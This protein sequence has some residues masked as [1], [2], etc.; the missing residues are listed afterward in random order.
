MA[1]RAYWKGYLKLSLVSCPIALFPATSEREKISFHQLNKKTGHRVKYRKVDAESGDEV[2]SADIIKGYEVGKGD[3]IELD[4]EELEAVAIESKRTIDIDEFVPK[5]EIDELYLNNPYYIAPD[6]EVG[7]QAF[8]VIREAIRKEGMVAIGKVVFTSREHI[9]ALEAR[10]KGLL[11]I[12][13]RYPYEVRNEADYFDDIPDEKIPKDMLDLASHIVKTKAGH[14]DTEQVRGP[15][16]GCAQGAA[17]KEA[18]RQAN[19][20][21]G[22]TQADKR[23]ESHGCASAECRGE[24]CGYI[25]QGEGP[26]GKLLAVHLKKPNIQSEKRRGVPDK[27]SCRKTALNDAQHRSRSS[28]WRYRGTQNDNGASELDEPFSDGE[29]SSLIR[30]GRGSAG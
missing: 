28:R 26:R 15:V 2:D 12:T 21:A 14:F 22:A 13:L 24:R 11:G 7:Q 6:G 9:I 17:Q 3:Y 5:D 10:G 16:R 4:P 18:G 1:P 30:G 8:A 19:R 27:L 29:Q 23:C 20:A 25:K